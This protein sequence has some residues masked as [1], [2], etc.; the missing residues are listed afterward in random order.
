MVCRSCGTSNGDDAENCIRCGRGL[1][2][3]VRGDVLSGRY[4]ILDGLGR[5][6]MGV[7]YK[8]HD[9]DLE[10]TVA[11]KVLRPD[12]AFSTDI[13]K[14]F[15]SEI[16]LARRVRHPNV[17]A[18]HEY[19]QEGALRYIVMEFVEG[20][21]LRQLLRK[22]GPL[23]STEAFEVAF[24]VASGLQ[25]IHALGIVHRD[26]KT[27]NLMKDPRGVVRL[28]DFGVAKQLG[29]E[30]VNSSAATQTGHIVGT[31]EYMSPE[32]ARGDPVDVRSDIYALGIVTF[33]LFTGDVPF[34]GDTPV[35]TL[36]MQMERE[37][38]L[39]ARRL[40]ARLVPVLK[41]ALAKE[42]RERYSSAEQMA[43][44]LRVAASS[45]GVQATVSLSR[46]ASPHA[47]L[48]LA[49]RRAGGVASAQVARQFPKPMSGLR[50]ADSETETLTKTVEGARTEIRNPAAPRVNAVR[51]LWTLGLPLMLVLAGG[52]YAYLTSGR[53]SNSLATRS[54]EGRS[55]EHFSQQ[56]EE[57]ATAPSAGQSPASTPPS[58]AI[59]PQKPAPPPSRTPSSARLIVAEPSARPSGG[60][61]P[62]ASPVH[63]EM[64]PAS[65]PTLSIP[66]PAPSPEPSPTPLQRLPETSSPRTLSRVEDDAS[67]KDIEAMRAVLKRYQEA[68]GGKN[69]RLLKEV[70][71]SLGGVTEREIRANFSFARSLHVELSPTSWH[72]EGDKSEVV[73]ARSDRLVSADGEELERSSTATFVLRR[74]AGSWFIE[75]IH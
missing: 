28:M 16:K 24:Q 51:W 3:L 43:Q 27:P 41:R 75:A 13:A 52:S 36:L 37:P 4:E 11:V 23:P 72:V 18:I 44:A 69:L 67:Q 42:R 47:A 56:S 61:R 6:G 64:S 71:P 19:G 33:E 62:S 10:E 31:P 63:Q 48:P 50:N 73:C 21:D 58:T 17:C 59:P 14:R 9:R 29:Q 55:V 38:P 30:R 22:R 32:Q 39:E 1:L 40:P 7:V 20:I 15:R 53:S 25:A 68:L 8:A 66:T 12:L 70:W 60:D 35:A 26:L 49:E 74:A 65:T 57:P 54:P 46:G 34:R 45:A 5:G 2:A